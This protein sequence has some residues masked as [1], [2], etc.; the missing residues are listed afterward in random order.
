[1]ATASRK[2]GKRLSIGVA[3]FAVLL[4][5]LAAL[6]WLAVHTEMGARAIWRIATA[7]DDRVAGEY[8]AGTLAD[9]L[10]LGNI[11]YRDAERQVVIDRI[12]VDWDWALSPL[13]L[14]IASLDVGVVEF[15]QL[16]APDE[17]LTL[18]QSLRLPLALKVDSATLQKLV[19][20]TETATQTY[21]DIALRGNSDGL[22]HR[23]MLQQAETPFGRASMQAYLKG[24]KPYK[25]SGKI[26]L[27]SALQGERYEVNAY[28]SGTLEKMNVTASAMGE[29]LSGQVDLIATPY[30]PIPFTNAR[31]RVSGLDLAAFNDSAPRTRLD[32]FAD[33]APVQGQVMP[34]T[35]TGLRVTG[36]ISIINHLPGRI[37]EQLL[38]VQ[39]I[40]AQAALD[41]KTQQLTDVV[42]RLAGNGVLTGSATNRNPLNG[43]L[44]LRA[45]DL[46]L[47]ALHGALQPTQL[48]GPLK[49]AFDDNRQQVH[50]D[51]AS[52][53]YSVK[54]DA[55][56][57]PL[58][59][60]LYSAEL[61]SGK[62]ILAL[63]GSLS[64]DE[65]FAYALEGKLSSFNPGL[66]IK[67]MNIQAPEPQQALPFRVYDANINGSFKAAGRLEPQLMAKVV[68]DIHD[69]TYNQLP[70]HGDGTVNI[71]G[72]QLLDSEAE[73]TIAGNHLALQGAFGKPGDQLLVNID[74][75]ALDKLGFG[76]AGLLQLDG[77]F[78]GTLEKPQVAAD[79]TAR[80]LQF[81]EHRLASAAGNIVMQ[82]LPDDNSDA[83]LELDIKARGYRSDLTQLERLDAQINGS[84]GN[85]SLR[86]VTAGQVRDQAIDLSLRAQGRLL[87]E[88]QGL[89]WSGTVTQFDNATMPRIHLAAPAT[90]EAAPQ[91]VKLGT[92]QITIAGA[93]LAIS[94]F[95]YE[96]GAISS[97][98]AADALDVAHLL[99]LRE[100]ITGEPVPLQTNLVLDASWDFRLAQQAQGFVQVARRSGDITSPA[101][102]GDIRLGLSALQL[103]GDFEG[104]R[105]RLR[106]NAEAERIGSLQG[107]GIIGLVSPGGTLTIAS[108]SPV[109][110]E[111]T[112][113]IPQLQKLAAF[114]GPRISVA[115]QIRMQLEVD[116]TLGNPQLSGMINGRQMAL[117]LYD[118]GIKLSDG[119][120]RIAL[121]NSILEMQQVEFH[122]GS[123]TLRITGSIPL[124]EELA[125]RPDLSANVIADNLQL[126]ADPSAQLTLTGRAR[127]TNTPE[128]YA[129]NGKFT[130]DRARF[131]LPEKAAPKL[132]DDVVVIRENAQAATVALQEPLS[133]REASPWTPAV[134]LDIN[135][136][137]RFYFQG[138]GADLRLVGQVSVTSQ[139]G[140]QPRVEGTV[141]VAE[142]TFEAFGAELAIERGIINFQGPM[143]NPNVNI[144]AMRRK[145]EV[146]AGV[147]VTG[148]ANNPR[149]VLVSE[150]DVPE[151]QKLSWLVFGNAGSGDGQGVAQTA[152][153]GAANALLNQLVEGSNIASNLGLDEISLGT[154]AS[155]GQLVTLGKSITDKLTLGYRQGITSAESAV[156]LTYLLTRHW[157]V[158][159]RGGQILG[160]NILYSNRFDEFGKRSPRRSEAEAA[161]KDDGQ[162]ARKGEADQ[163]N[164]AGAE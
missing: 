114:A 117:T 95:T 162:D 57:D 38:P 19:I 110:G 9:G 33:I 26:G 67:T 32:I 87:Q 98:G 28:F 4:A 116:G 17:P 142:G 97:A 140:R 103:R 158:V 112:L 6:L 93:K 48:S 7:M 24:E 127:I 84:Y 104:Q 143:D 111:V 45:Q 11:A 23:F 73:L 81:A 15:T 78:A 88:E 100:E 50:L 69:S 62:A 55:R 66:F 161:G 159:A 14:S 147:Q 56:I 43:S 135:L 41:A 46:N 160:V 101:K 91:R 39:S 125:A 148:S 120:A 119:T 12:A 149:V 99:K 36:P 64:R 157:S 22:N 10:Q 70:M 71:A 27:D 80:N 92:A 59:V 35:L 108:V 152:A 21:S 51:L 1:M 2:F 76:L 90:L 31:I 58:K 115:G 16:P 156:E 153:R 124:G 13:K 164:S 89:A 128:H 49:I 139:P 74:A 18:P 53:N 61:K 44:Y 129:V 126:L 86:L 52:R 75:P 68:F 107:N 131:D 30:A 5:L 134:H 37:D 151:D 96:A 155:G 154:S 121:R 79:F 106:G 109:E 25:L 141:R 138:R 60:V 54:A 42:I 145:Q 77:R 29:K 123:G 146:A 83:T 136:G 63:S 40:S 144:L 65:K 150:P 34:E 105:L 113:S 94:H 47:A 82:G 133:K 72:K 20:Q 132:G 118:Q 130:V 137:N 8:Q 102:T 3:A 163:S 85:H 122:G